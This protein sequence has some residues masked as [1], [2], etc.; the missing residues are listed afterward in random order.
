MLVQNSVLFILLGL[1]CLN[2]L[3][4]AFL[5]FVLF[6]VGPDVISNTLLAASLTTVT[7]V[8]LSFLTLKSFFALQSVVFF[9]FLPSD[10]SEISNLSF[11][12]SIS[13]DS[14]PSDATWLLGFST[15]TVQFLIP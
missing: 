4:G 7:P 13:T 14:L 1:F 5:N 2:F 10:F 15:I 6:F 9:Q 8:Y 11:L 3:L 12:F